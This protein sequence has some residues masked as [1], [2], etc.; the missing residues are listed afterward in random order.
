MLTELQTF[1]MPG[2]KGVSYVP[3]GPFI[4]RFHVRSVSFE[5]FEEIEN[6]WQQCL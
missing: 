2:K 4:S 6:I 5:L 3:G 1:Y